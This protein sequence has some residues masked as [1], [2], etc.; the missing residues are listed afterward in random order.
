MVVVAVV[1]LMVVAADD[2]VAQ[3]GAPLH[4]ATNRTFSIQVP[5]FSLTGPHPM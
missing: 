2:V 5:I 3:V 4:K 1:K